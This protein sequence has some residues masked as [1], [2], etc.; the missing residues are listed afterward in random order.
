LGEIIM[1]FHADVDDM[2]TAAGHKKLLQHAKNFYSAQR[3][4]STNHWIQ[5][6]NRG[7]QQQQ[8]GGH[9]QKQKAAVSYPSFQCP[10]GKMGYL[11]DD[12]CDC[13]DGSDEPNTSACSNRLVQRPTFTCKHNRGGA[14]NTTTTIIFASRVGDGIRDCPDGS[15]EDEHLSSS[16]LAASTSRQHQL[17]A[18]R[19]GLVVE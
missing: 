7:Q 11:N 2:A 15:D 6:H 1:R 10:D 12:Y 13:L 16:Q 17:D 19:A 5:H 18:F 8:H 3:N 9:E 14:A 4:A